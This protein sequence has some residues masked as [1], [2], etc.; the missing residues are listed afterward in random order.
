MIETI[1]IFLPS[2]IILDFMELLP[3]MVKE[4]FLLNKSIFFILAKLNFVLV[5][6]R[7]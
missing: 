2:S 1:M 5:G 4:T 6:S 3:C 7:N